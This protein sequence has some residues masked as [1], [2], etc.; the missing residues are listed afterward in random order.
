M[1]AYVMAADMG[2]VPP[3]PAYR[4]FDANSV[5][6]AAILGSPVAGA[7]LMAINYRRMGKAQKAILAV[8][9][10]IVATVAGSLLGYFVPA[11]ATTVVAITLA[12]ATK[13]AA[14][15]WQ[16]RVVADHFVRGG[17]LSS[18]WAAAGVG[19][20]FLA[21]F[22]GVIFLGALGLGARH[23]VIIGSHDEVYYLGSATEQDAR[24]LG[25]ALTNEG[26]FQDRGF[27]VVLSKDKDG[28]AIS[29]VVKDGVW[30]QPEMLAGFQQMGRE[31]APSV[32]GL[33]VKVRLVDALRQTKKELSVSQ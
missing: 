19:V 26:Y 29:F 9:V 4:L 11:F 33:P 32:G 5:L 13:G 30:D 10:A 25:A 31:L 21:V 3:A 22:F 23:K 7:T 27:V 24:A 17:G 2:S 16:G 12:L 18:K 20:A 1:S 6:I 28:T 8:A 15:H 14:Q